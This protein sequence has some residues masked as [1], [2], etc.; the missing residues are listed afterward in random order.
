MTRGNTIL[1]YQEINARE[2]D[3]CITRYLN[4]QKEF[5]GKRTIGIALYC[6][7]IAIVCFFTVLFASRSNVSAADAGVPIPVIGLLF[8]A[9]LGVIPFL[10]GQSTIVKARKKYGRPFVGRTNEF[11]RLGEDG[12]RYGYHPVNTYGFEGMNVYQISYSD[13]RGVHFD[14]ETN[15]LS[16][17]GRGSITVFDDLMMTI[18][19]EELSGKRFY[20]NSDY[21][22]MLAT[23]NSQQIVDYLKDKT[24]GG[25]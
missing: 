1:E 2:K 16:I 13:I 25:K 5:R 12:L 14:K 21:Q 23:T 18:P 10:I 4:K 8:G 24:Q 7:A 9:V 6:L 19:N 17:M 3:R 20:D 11:F 15:V 22:I